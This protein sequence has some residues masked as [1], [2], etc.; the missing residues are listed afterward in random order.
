MLNQYFKNIEL[1]FWKILNLYLKN[2]E[3]QYF[4]LTFFSDVG[5][6]SGGRRGAR[7]VGLGLREWMDG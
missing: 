1:A 3:P 6:S 5:G 2:V 7:G 4:F